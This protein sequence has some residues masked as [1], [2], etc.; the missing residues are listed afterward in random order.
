MTTAKG[1]VGVTTSSAVVSSFPP[2]TFEVII[3]FMRV[4]ALMI[5]I[6]VFWL[7]RC[8][9]DWKSLLWCYIGAIIGV[10]A[11]VGGYLW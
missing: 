2:L 9:E 11:I 5:S 4:G 1:V 10:V 7:I 8:K 3:A 6:M